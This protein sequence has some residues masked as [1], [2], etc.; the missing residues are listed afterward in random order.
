MAARELDAK[1]LLECLGA[2]ETA[3]AEDLMRGPL[4]GRS[5]PEGPA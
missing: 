2:R 3:K 5:P 4:V 1:V